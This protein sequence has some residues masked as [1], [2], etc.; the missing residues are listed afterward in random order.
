MNRQQQNI[1]RKKRRR[2]IVFSLLAC[3]IFFLSGIYITNDVMME[4]TGMPMEQNI[5]SFNRVGQA[6][7]GINQNAQNIPVKEIA[8][9]ALNT[10][11]KLMEW[12]RNLVNS[13]VSRI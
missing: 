8:N 6:L 3:M 9:N 1:I 2:F 11:L 13:L 12:F 7:H 4:M 5:F 10:G